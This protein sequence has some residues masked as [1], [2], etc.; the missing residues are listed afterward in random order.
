[1]LLQ[2]GVLVAIGLGVSTVVVAACYLTYLDSKRAA[3]WMSIQSGKDDSS[4]NGDGGGGGGEG[5]GGG[6]YKHP[7]VLHFMPKE[8]TYEFSCVM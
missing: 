7:P 1:M 6:T 4:D 5:G 8:D 3:E 2:V